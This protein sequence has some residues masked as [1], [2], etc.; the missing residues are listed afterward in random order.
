MAETVNPSSIPRCECPSEDV[1]LEYLLGV[2][3]DFV[4]VSIDTHISTCDPC[5][6][7]LTELESTHG[8]QLRE[9]LQAPSLHDATDPAPVEA[10]Q[11]IDA[12]WRAVQQRLCEDLSTGASPVSV[13]QYRI[14]ERIGCGGMGSVYR[15]E[16][17]QLKKIVALKLIPT[18][19]SHP[20]TL[21]R[22]EREIRAAGQLQHPGIVTATDAGTHSGMQYLAMEFVDGLDLGKLS[23]SIC[24]IPTADAC[25]IARQLSLALA[26]AHPL[27]IIHRDI[28][29]SN[30]MLDRM[31]HVKLFDFGLVHFHRWDGPVGELTTVGQFLGTLDYMAPEQAERS[32]VVDARSDLYSLGATLFKLLTGQTPL[33]MTPHQSPIEKL[34]RLSQHQ[35]IKLQTLRPDLH[36]E[37]CDIVNRLLATQPDARLPSALHVAQAL[38]PFCES[39]DLAGLATRAL[40]SEQAHTFDAG[41]ETIAHRRPNSLSQSDPSAS[42]TQS[43][44]RRRPP[45]WAWVALAALPL[46]GFFGWRILLESDQGNLVIESASDTT[47]IEIKRRAGGATQEMTVEPGAQLTHLYA[48]DYDI[49]IHEGSDQVSIEPKQVQL[50]RGETVIARIIRSQK[51]ESGSTQSGTMGTA[52]AALPGELRRSSFAGVSLPASVE[53]ILFKGKSLS[54]WLLVLERERDPDE[55]K[56]A[57]EA[58]HNADPQL[59][60]SLAHAIREMGLQHHFFSPVENGWF[61]PVFSHDEFD[62]LVLESIQGESLQACLEILS[63]VAEIP[64]LKMRNGD[65]YQA[66]RLSQSWSFVEEKLSTSAPS[67]EL[68]NVILSSKLFHSIAKIKDTDFLKTHPWIAFLT[69][70]I[71]IDTQRDKEFTSTIA[72]LLNDPKLDLGRFLFL[73]AYTPFSGSAD[74]DLDAWREQVRERLANELHRWAGSGK[75]LGGLGMGP[76]MV[77]TNFDG[78]GFGRG[79]STKGIGGGYWGGGP[80]GGGGMGGGGMGGAYGGMNPNEPSELGLQ[81][82]ALCSRIPRDLRPVEA[83]EQLAMSMRP[84]AANASESKSLGGISWGNVYTFDNEFLGELTAQGMRK[85]TEPEVASGLLRWLDQLRLGDMVAHGEVVNQFW[86]ALKRPATANPLDWI[87]ESGRDQSKIDQLMKFLPESFADLEL[88]VSH[89][90]LETDRSVHH[91]SFVVGPGMGVGQDRFEITLKLEPAGWR[92]ATFKYGK[93]IIEF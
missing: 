12:A 49:T 29:P 67:S 6:Q 22:F 60:N 83:I 79:N 4:S 56:K 34:K 40:Q 85:L 36:P 28:K 78:I 65:V 70:R 57:F 51:Q 76:M 50:R 47:K 14:L 61:L 88:G 53:T 81:L 77:T 93:N 20:Q 35:P 84:I 11:A 24:P 72:T 31:G 82:L 10:Q 59:V 80:V 39:S 23:R 27:G 91:G 87:V 75:V 16:H 58:L 33:A 13:G 19:W 63:A 17:T 8:A 7:R 44:A 71:Q 15:A 37:L 62:R 89:V 46:F 55:W 48:G 64:K 5:N 18:E 2:A 45:V 41:G 30:V 38:Q 54:E 1:L 86:N 43:S 32:D 21:Q 90:V 52:T 3:D 74:D 42:A 66:S 68:L 25:E 73:A 9:T 26:H 92:V 69:H